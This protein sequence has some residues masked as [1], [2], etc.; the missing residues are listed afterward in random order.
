MENI[1]INPAKDIVWDLTTFYKNID[2]P[3]IELTKKSILKEAKNFSKKYRGKIKDGELSPTKLFGVI[4][5]YEFI[6]IALAELSS[7]SNLLQSKNS[8]SDKINKFYQHTHE[9]TNDI[10]NILMFFELEILEIP[11][12]KLNNFISSKILKEYKLFLERI[13]KF[14]SHTLP[15]EQEILLNKKHQTG[16]SAFV[17]LYDQISTD[18]V[19]ELEINSKVYNYNYSEITN[20]LSSHKDREVREKAAN[21][22]TETYS[23][24]SRVFA[25]ILNTLLLDKKINDDIRSYKCPQESTFL[26]DEIKGSIV[27]TMSETIKKKYSISEKFYLAKSKLLGTDLYEWDR[28]SEIFPEAGEKQ[29]RYEEAKSLILESFEEFSPQFSE[30]AEKFFDNNWIDAEI[31]K[32][33]KSGAF[34]AYITPNKH[35]FI[36]TNFTGKV[37][38]VRT[39]AHE[40]G[41][42]IHAYLSR[43]QN[44]LNYYPVTPLAEI[45]SIFC[46]NLVFRKIYNETTDIKQKINLLG[47]RLQE[48][49]AT[50]FRQN[51]FYLFESEIHEKRRVE[52]ELSVSTLNNLFQQHLQRMFGSGLTLT[53]GHQYWWMPIGHFYHY[54]FYVFSYAFGQSMSNA[55]YGAYL[56]DGA[57][58]VANYTEVLKMG[59]SRD[60]P[61]LT[62]MLQVDIHK[63]S[64]WQE[65]LEPIEDFV[66]EFEKLANSNKRMI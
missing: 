19:F 40:L 42:G 45:A 1:S 30:I 14:Q 50:I 44:Y 24:N 41:H 20:I 18:L 51:A 23:K 56:N 48:I 6:L 12:E 7:F 5:K 58:F 28:Y 9:F 29:Y 26:G 2:D 21:A 16:S 35:P 27:K 53:E 64:F 8:S 25:F 37:N 33:K 46:E 52:G 10:S 34:C 15:E 63:P 31:S 39:L 32:G 49:F 3:A 4:K 47:G 17:R 61:G 54:N 57:E 36:L 55:L 66:Q 59:S 65:G 11:K 13:V 62:K 22:I 43:E 60:L 38:D